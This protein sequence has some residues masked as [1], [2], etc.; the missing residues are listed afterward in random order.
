MTNYHKT[1]YRVVAKQQDLYKLKIED[2][3]KTARLKGNFFYK[4][5]TGSDFPQVGDWVR[6]AIY[7]DSILIEEVLE[8]AT[9]ISRKVAG[10][11]TEEQ[12]IAANIDYV[13]IVLGLDGGRNY[14]DRLLERYMTIAW[15]SGATPLVI[16][17]KADLNDKAELFKSQAETVAPGVD[18]IISSVKDNTGI[19]TIFDHLADGK[20][21][22]FIG[23]SG[24]GK[25]ALTNALLNREVQKTG[26]QRSNDKRG[27]HTTSSS[28][29]FE[30]SNG[31][32]I[33]DSPGLRE[34][35]LWADEDDLDNVFDEISSLAKNCRFNDCQ[36]QGEPGCAVQAALES[37]Q[38]T[39]ERYNSYLNLKKEIAFLQIKKSEKSVYLERCRSKKFTKLCKDILKGKELMN[40]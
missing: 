16:L 33:I 40:K 4:A 38:I 30:L 18:I 6:A 34:I 10:N 36:H 29:M 8:R 20:V 23:P 1:K 14:S 39:P 7:E 11:N 12:I 35:Q 32:Y 25:S 3:I 27:R 2:Q 22:V 13:A 37:G 31:G 9:R 15:D 28:K 19:A 24:V 5:K 21:S 26:A 17:N